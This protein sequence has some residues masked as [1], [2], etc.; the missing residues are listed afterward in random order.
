[1]KLISESQL[2]NEQALSASVVP[3]AIYNRQTK[4][5]IDCNDKILQLFGYTNKAEFLSLQLEDYLYENQFDDTSRSELIQK[6]M[7]YFDQHEIFNSSLIGL[8]QDK[9]LI[10]LEFFATKNYFSQGTHTIFYF[11]EINP[12]YLIKKIVLDKNLVYK[13]IIEKAF[14]YIDIHKVLIINR[15]N[16]EYQGVLLH[17]SNS[18]KKELGIGNEPLISNKAITQL[19]PPRFL[20]ENSSLMIDYIVELRDNKNVVF[21]WQFIK[22]DQSIVDLNISSTLITLNNNI[23]LIR[24]MR[25]ISAQIQREKLIQLQNEEL[26]LNN[27][28]LKEYIES[29][30]ALQNFANIASHDMKAPL[31]TI[32]GFSKILKN[33]VSDKLDE[34][35]KKMLQYIEEGGHNLS[36]LVDDL[37]NFSS[38]NEK[39]ITLELIDTKQLL[40]NL[41]IHLDAIITENNAQI[42]ILE[43]PKEIVADK[44][45]ILRVFQNLIQNAIKFKKENT[46]PS[47]KIFGSQDADFWYFNINDNGIGIKKEFHET[48]FSMF[49]KL[50]GQEIKGTGMGLSLCKNIVEQHEGSITV[51]S[52]YGQG[53][54]FTFLI[55]K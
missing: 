3:M 2:Y 10:L 20:E 37:L 1:M 9:S 21:N 49:S 11:K 12:D 14:D 51:R 13:S 33:R 42:H 40:D 16:F 32:V 53:S 39:K 41:L 25:N 45:K 28:K 7:G 19:T 27:T 29:N 6:I 52:E 4:K 36:L 17:R 47:I 15:D 54:T 43:I 55:K 22:T 48:I 44:L 38:I 18:M 30:L 34:S 24:I 35:E 5:F 23:Y 46:N 8:R 26:Q 31:R 50:N